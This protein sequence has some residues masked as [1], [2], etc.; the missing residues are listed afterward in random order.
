MERIDI[1]LYLI[2]VFKTERPDGNLRDFKNKL[3]TLSDDDL[4]RI[5]DAIDR[6]GID[7]LI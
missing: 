1:Y 4:L 6:F 7:N 3:Y 2:K 5:A